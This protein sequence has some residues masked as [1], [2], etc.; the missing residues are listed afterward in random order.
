M[1]VT[2]PL[3]TIDHSLLTPMVPNAFKVLRILHTALFCSM[4]LFAGVCLFIVLTHTTVADESF[5]R[6]MQL[7]CILLSFASILIGFRIFKK[8]ILAARNSTAPAADRMVQYRSAC[9]VWWAMIEGPGLLAGIGFLVTANYAFFALVVV[10]VLILGLF[11][12]RKSNIVVLLNLNAAEV[13]QLEG[14]FS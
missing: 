5:D 10:H 12:P 1:P 3:F 14:T 13:K 6:T 9:I 4:L 8:K 7:V 11:T 2:R